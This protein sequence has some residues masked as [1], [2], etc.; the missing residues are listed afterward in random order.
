MR[1][2]ILLLLASFCLFL[3]SGFSNDTDFGVVVEVEKNP[4]IGPFLRHGYYFISDNQQDIQTGLPQ[5]FQR[6]A[7]LHTRDNRISILMK[8]PAWII[9]DKESSARIDEIFNLSSAVITRGR[10]RFKL[11]EGSSNWNLVMRQVRIYADPGSDFVLDTSGV[12]LSKIIVLDGAIRFNPGNERQMIE[13]KAGKQATIQS[14]LDPKLEDT[15]SALSETLFRVLSLPEGKDSGEYSKYLDMAKS[16]NANRTEL[17][18]KPVRFFSGINCPFCGFT[19][20]KHEPA[21][22]TC[23]NCENRLLTPKDPPKATEEDS[24]VN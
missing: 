13:V 6:G 12:L 1:K 9:F 10:I 22:K 5:V 4:S 2:R 3:A 20:S 19:F 11:L 24:K 15:P 8:N 14:D 7:M 21:K 17:W 18:P 23:P 16:F